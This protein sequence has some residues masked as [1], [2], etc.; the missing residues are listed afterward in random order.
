MSF[1]PRREAGSLY[2]AVE[3][4]GRERRWVL[5]EALDLPALV[6]GQRYYVPAV[7]AQV[8]RSLA[9]PSWQLRVGGN[10]SWHPTLEEAQFSAR[11][12]VLAH[13]A[14]RRL[15]GKPLWKSKNRK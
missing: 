8:P 13:E 2:W 6:E 15:Q 5:M 9:R 14:A 11:E 12:A 7:I 4:F 10:N 1:G 3:T